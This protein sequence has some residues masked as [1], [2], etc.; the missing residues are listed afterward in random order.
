M[1]GEKNGNSWV[2]LAGAS[3]PS[4]TVILGNKFQGLL[5]VSTS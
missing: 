2:K 5:Q 1:K 3:F 4:Y